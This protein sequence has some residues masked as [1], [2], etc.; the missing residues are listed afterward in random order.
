MRSINDDAAPGAAENHPKNATS[1]SSPLLPPDAA[2]PALVKYGVRWWVCCVFASIAF[3]QGLGWNTY[4]PISGSYKAIY[5]WDDAMI[6]LLPNVQGI[7]VLVLAIPFAA[8]QHTLDLRTAVIFTSTFSA[9]CLGVRCVPCQ[10]SDH[11]YWSMASMVANGISNSIN[12][13]YPTALSATWY[14]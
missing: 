7:V 14:R 1:P 2:R 10:R 5:G 3:L 12:A 13:V 9:I 4:A 8:F 11:Y 6:A